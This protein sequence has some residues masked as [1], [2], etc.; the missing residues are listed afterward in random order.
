MK[1]TQAYIVGM[2]GLETE[3]RDAGVETIGGSDPAHNPST[4]TPP[5]LT[6]VRADFDDKVNGSE[7]IPGNN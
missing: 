6:D 3:L 7:L 5:D 1:F 4:T 2:E